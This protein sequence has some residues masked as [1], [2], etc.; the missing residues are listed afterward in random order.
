MAFGGYDPSQEL[1]VARRR[2][3]AELLMK[4]G[5]QK[6]T[7]VIGGYAV[8]QSPLEG[9][10]RALQTGLGAY[11]SRA[12]DTTEADMKQRQA[13]LIMNAGQQLSSGNDR[14][15]AA[16]LMQ[17]PSTA[18]YGFD[19]IKDDNANNRMLEIAK[20]RQQSG[21]PY[22]DP[23]TGE[24]VAP[25]PKLSATQQKE[26]FDTVDAT[27]AGQA[28][29][30]DLGLAEKIQSGETGVKPY[31]GIGA[32]T[33]AAANRIPGIG[34]FIDDKR[35]AA[36]TDY[37]NLVSQQALQS[38]K[39]TFGGNPTE[40]E[41]AILLKLQALPS[42]SVSEQKKILENARRAAEDKVR[43]NQ[44]KAKYIQ[45]GDFRGLANQSSAP[46]ATMNNSAQ[47]GIKFL[48]FE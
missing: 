30:R 45:T 8:K 29:L 21:Q 6:P 43:F 16:T 19:F 4:Q 3:Y 28:S 31:S 7:E 32:E 26:L 47:G 5:E 41:R 1:E 46:A 13:D 15:A 22:V 35:A 18:K 36:T 33:L 42:Y 39:S 9:L 11:Q 44:Q 27:N 38:L 37:S 14:E 24:L 2:K 17:D 25:Q 48:G 12:A 34:M 20:L 10:T 40:G 23:E